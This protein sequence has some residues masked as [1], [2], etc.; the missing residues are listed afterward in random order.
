MAYVD[1][2]FDCLVS[3]EEDFIVQGK[4]EGIMAGKEQVIL[5]SICI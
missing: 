3:F 5:L 1:N 2:L 4:Q